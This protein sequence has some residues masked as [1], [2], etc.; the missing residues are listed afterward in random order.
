[1]SL[2]YLSCAW[3]VGIFFGSI[4]L[5]SEFDLP[6]LFIFIGLIPLPLLFL[7][8]QHKK[9]IILTSFCLIILI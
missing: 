3:V 9:L 1:M 5:E 8:R 7:A 2:I 6:L 4:F